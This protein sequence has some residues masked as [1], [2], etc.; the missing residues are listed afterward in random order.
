M[1]SAESSHFERRKTIFFRDSRGYYI[2]ELIQK[3]FGRSNGVEVLHY[4]GAGLGTLTKNGHNYADFRLFDMLFIA[5]GIC[6]ITRKDMETKEIFFEWDDSVEL[7][8][9]IIDTIEKE[10]EIFKAKAPG[11]KLVFCNFVGAD[12][13]K[14]LKRSAEVE[15]RILE[16]PKRSTSSTN[17]SSRKTLSKKYMRQIWLLLFT[18]TQKNTCLFW[19]ILDRTE[20]MWDLN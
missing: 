20:Y 3:E 16:R 15:Q 6:N 19:N 11:S 14:V 17:I 1:A 4:K 8:S 18:V 5:E 7:A 9:H 12:L 13:S 2:N 10:K